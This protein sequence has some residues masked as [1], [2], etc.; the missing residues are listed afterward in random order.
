MLSIRSR[1]WIQDENGRLV[2]GEGR[3]KI[4]RS[5]EETGS[6][7]VSAK[8]LGMSYRAIWGKIRATES[9]LGQPLLES[10]KAKG[11]VLTPMAKELVKRYEEFS[12]RCKVAEERIF[13]ET[14]QGL[15]EPDQRS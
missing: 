6:L 13:K 15:I 11:S 8:A 4:L 3:L 12:Q 9:A 2:M 10:T 7:A 1:H 14:F 5:V